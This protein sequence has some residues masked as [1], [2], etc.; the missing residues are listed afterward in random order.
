MSIPAHPPPFHYDTYL[1]PHSI[2]QPRITTTHNFQATM[3]QLPFLLFQFRDTFGVSLK[4]N[5]MLLVIQLH[6]PANNSSS[7]MGSQLVSHVAREKFD[8]LH[9]AGSIIIY[10]LLNHSYSFKQSIL[11]IYTH[12]NI[13]HFPAPNHQA[14]GM[15]HILSTPHCSS[16][17]IQ[18]IY[19]NDAFDQ[20]SY[21]RQTP[22]QEQPHIFT[23]KLKTVFSQSS[24][25][26]QKNRSYPLKNTQFIPIVISATKQ[27]PKL[28]KSLMYFILTKQ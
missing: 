25:R 13:W 8:I 20:P 11:F 17:I 21:G 26:S 19:R 22:R 1:A 7:K 28:R 24:K 9:R 23:Q 27:V 15:A 4:H 2:S 5:R 3:P 6:E 10:Q 14:S 16:H 18:D 12:S